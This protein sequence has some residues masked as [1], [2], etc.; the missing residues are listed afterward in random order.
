M[1]T[2]EERAQ[3]EELRGIIAKLRSPDGGCPW[4]LEQTHQSLR[5]H[6]IEEAYE[7]LAA[8]DADDPAQ[9]AEEL[10]DLLFHVLL[11]TQLAEDAGEFAMTDVL[12]GLADKLVRR[13]PHVF[14][15]VNMETADQVV[16]QWDQLKAKERSAETSA[17]ASVP[18]ALPALSY[19][20]V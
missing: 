15:D 7:V 11:H 18:G 19:A 14:G 3:Y 5:P 17:L 6:L 12:S 20:Q 9:L 8:L 13:H 1:L 16:Q 4:D 10:G 2:P